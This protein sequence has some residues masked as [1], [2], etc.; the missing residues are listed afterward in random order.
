MSKIW[1]LGNYA[2]PTK[3]ATNQA[4]KIVIEIKFKKH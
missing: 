1:G 3:W 2:I 4:F